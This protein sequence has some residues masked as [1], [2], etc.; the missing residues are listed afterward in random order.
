MDGRITYIIRCEDGW[1]CAVYGT[2]K[3]AVEKAERHI[4]ESCK[5][6]PQL[7]YLIM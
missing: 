6:D 1:M 3:E 2:Y 4:K 7:T 5:G